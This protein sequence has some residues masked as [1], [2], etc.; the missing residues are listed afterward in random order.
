MG[1]WGDS[2]EIAKHCERERTRMWNGFERLRPKLAELARYVYPQ[3]LA[4]LT[5]EP[6]GLTEE[7]PYDGDDA[8]R[9]TSVAMDAFKIAHNGFHVNLTN[10]SAPWFRL[11]TPDFGAGRGGGERDWQSRQSEKLTKATQWLIAW[12]GAYDAVHT[13]YKHLVMAGFGALFTQEDP[14][15]IVRTE[16]LRLGTY[17]LGIDRRGRPDRLVRRFALTAEQLVEEF[18]ARAVSSGVAE[19]AKLGDGETKHEVWC[20]VEPHRKPPW[21]GAAR[22]ALSYRDFRYRAVYWSQE[23]GAESEHGLLAVRGYRVKP[24]VA[25]RLRLE[26]GDVYGRGFAVDV[27]GQMREL[28]RLAEVLGDTAEGDTN[29]PLAAPASMADAGLRLG[30]GDVNYYPDNLGPNA[31]YRVLGEPV[32]TDKTEAEFAR[33]EGEVRKAFFNSEFETINAMR[34]GAASGSGRGNMTAT[35]VRARVS[36]K[37]EQLAGVATTLNFEFLDPFVSMMAAYAIISGLT[38]AEVPESADGAAFPWDVKYESA[39]HAAAY[40][41]PINAALQSLDTV[42]ALASLAQDASAM[43]N[44]DVD[45]WVRDVHRKLGAPE[46][47]LRPEEER[48]AMRAE[49]EEA[50]RAA[51]EAER[52]AV[53]AK[54]LKDTAGAP[55]TPGTIG[56]ALAEAGGLAGGTGVD[57][58]LVA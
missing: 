29:P 52:A 13:L 51:A 15:R 55:V 27:L 9:R 28:Q 21:S 38:D 14:E 10:P 49:R 36:E 22:Y 45:A 46:T 44:F 53:A 58:G 6:R 8:A 40:A 47:Y 56:G 23:A 5:Q 31:V 1:R 12:S 11:R 25:P 33:L 19:A 4:G 16:C 7:T 37:M 57:G 42:S 39:I 43:D 30:P 48:E 50:S 24:F 26:S 17:A 20:L 41:Q 32:K 54:A 3:A 35:E 34:D 2:A 18:G